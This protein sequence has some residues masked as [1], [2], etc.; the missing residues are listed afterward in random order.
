MGEVGAR[1][2][3]T[4]IHLTG[5]VDKVLIHFIITLKT[6]YNHSEKTT[7][8]GRRQNLQEQAKF[9][10]EK[11]KLAFQPEEVEKT[12]KADEKYVKDV[13]FEIRH[14]Q[15]TLVNRFAV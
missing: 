15:V 2:A 4:I 10:G 6:K 8:A 9:L 1:S 13:N 7:A 3:L 14:L 12:S 11:I 5:Y